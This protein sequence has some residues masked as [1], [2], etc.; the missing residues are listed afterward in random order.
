[1][2][3]GEEVEDRGTH[4]VKGLDRPVEVYELVG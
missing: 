3:D 2:D 1:M 4:S